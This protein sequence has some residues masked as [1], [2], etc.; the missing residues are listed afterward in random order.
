VL[1]VRVH[2]LVSKDIWSRRYA[3]I[4]SF[5]QM[6]AEEGTTI[7]K[8]YLNITKDEQKQRLQERLDTPSKNWKFNPGDLK[9]RALWDDYASAYEDT[10]NRTSAAWAPW[11]V[12]PAN[13]NWYRNLCVASILVKTLEDLKMEYPAPAAD[14]SSI[15]ID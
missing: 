7:V 8:F 14:L 9:E 1:I 5:E 13:R 4:S 2:N 11:Y 12:I 6:L 10:F 15:I 3:Q